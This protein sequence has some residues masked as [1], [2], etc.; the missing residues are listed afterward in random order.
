MTRTPR[1]R[2]RPRPRRCCVSCR[3]PQSDVTPGIDCNFPRRCRRCRCPPPRR[4]CLRRALPTPA[5]GLRLWQVLFAA[6]R[7]RR[8]HRRCRHLLLRHQT[9]ALETR[10]RCQRRWVPIFPTFKGASC[11]ISSPM[12]GIEIRGVGFRVWALGFRGWALGFRVWAL[13]FMVQGRAVYV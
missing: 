5:V 11:E 3:P 2:P 7:Q 12:L 4:H 1:P 9:P 6:P 10:R 13:G 8:Y